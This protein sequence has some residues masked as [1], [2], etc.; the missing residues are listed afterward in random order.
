MKIASIETV[1]IV[2]G[3]FGRIFGYGSIKVTGRGISDLIYKNIDN[4]MDVKKAI[5]SIETK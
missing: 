3:V 5:E 2:Q 1:E 4:P